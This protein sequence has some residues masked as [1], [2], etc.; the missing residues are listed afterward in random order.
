MINH[1][2]KYHKYKTK[3]LKLKMGG[4]LSSSNKIK[5][6]LYHGSPFNLKVIKTRLPRGV[7]EF[8]SYKAV[9]M[10]DNLNL[11]KIYAITRDK[12]RERRGWGAGIFKGKATLF[13]R[14]DKFNKD[15]PKLN[16]I[17]YVYKYKTDDYKYDKATNQYR[18]DRDVIPDSKIVVNKED[19][20][21]LITF[22]TKDEMKKIFEDIL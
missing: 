18:I 6:V 3:Y 7:T 11:A 1:E 13:L 2:R 17:G 9:Y 4:F 21:D 14:K 8:D 16:E 12:K 5:K 10:T 20:S 22:V 19:I 15:D